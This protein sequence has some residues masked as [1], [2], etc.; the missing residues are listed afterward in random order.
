MTR[1]NQDKNESQAKGNAAVN[2]ALK[3]KKKKKT[4]VI[5]SETKGKSALMLI[6]CRTMKLKDAMI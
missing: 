1:C 6:G 3:K 4:T 2:K 5:E